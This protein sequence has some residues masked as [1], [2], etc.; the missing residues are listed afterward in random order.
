MKQISMA[1]LSALVFSACAK[2]ESDFNFLPPPESDVRSGVALRVDPP[3]SGSLAVLSIQEGASFD[4]GPRSVNTHTTQTFTLKNES[5]SAPATQISGSANLGSGFSYVGGGFPGFSGTCGDTLAPQQS[6]TFVIEFN[7]LSLLS[8]T[9]SPLISYHDGA[10]TNSTS[11]LLSGIGAAYPTLKFEQPEYSFG[12]VNLGETNEMSLVVKYYGVHPA[13][14]IG[15][16]TL[17]SPW[18][19]KGGSYPGLGG[20]CRRDEIA[21]D[22]RVVVTFSPTQAGPNSKI[23]KLRYNNGAF[24]DDAS[25]VIGGSGYG[26]VSPR[27][28][29]LKILDNVN[30]PLRLVNTQSPAAEVRVKNDGD[31]AAT[32]VRP[33][34]LGDG[35]EIVGGGTCG[36]TIPTGICTFKVVFRPASIGKFSGGLTLIYDDGVNGWGKRVSNM[37]AGRAGGPPVLIINDVSPYDYGEVSVGVTKWHDF[38]ISNSPDSIAAANVNIVNTVF[39]F[40]SHWNMSGFCGTEIAPGASCKVGV[41][42]SP[43]ELGPRSSQFTVSYGYNDGTQNISQPTLLQQVKGV[44]VENA[45]LAID[46][47]SVN[48]GKVFVSKKAS[49]T[50]KLVYVG[51][52]VP[53]VIK[54]YEFHSNGKTTAVPF[55]Q[56]ALNDKDECAGPGTKMNKTCNIGL[57]FTPPENLSYGAE[58]WVLYDDGKGNTKTAKAGL[59]GI[60]LYEGALTV[61]PNPLAFGRVKLGD[62]LTKNV[63]LTAKAGNFTDVSV[64]EV[65]VTGDEFKLDEANKADG[66]SSNTGKHAVVCARVAAG[67]K[68]SVP[69]K[70]TPSNDGTFDGKVTV[71]WKADEQT[72]STSQTIGLTGEGFRAGIVEVTPNPA[73]IE[74]TAV[75]QSNSVTVTVKNKGTANVTDLV[76]ASGTAGKA[77]T[78]NEMALNSSCGSTL[79]TSGSGSSC[80]FQ[81]S[82][83]PTKPGDREGEVVVSFNDG[84]KNDSVKVP[85]KARSTVQVQLASGGDHACAITAIGQVKCWGRNDYGQLGVGGVDSKGDAGGEMGSALK[86]VNLGNGR[87]AKSVSVGFFHTCAILDNDTLKCWGRNDYGQLGIGNFNHKGM[88]ESDMGDALPGVALGGTVKAVEAGYVHTCAILTDGSVKCWGLNY[89]GQLGLGDRTTRNAPS[90]AADIGGSAKSISL[91]AGHTC[92]VLTNNTL[93]CWGDNW[94]GQLG[95][96]DERGRGDDAGEMGSALAAIELGV[97]VSGVTAAGGYTC[98]V[99]SNGDMKCFGRNQEGTLGTCWALNSSNVAGPCWETGYTRDTRGYG[100]YAGQMSTLPK[101]DLGSFSVKTAAAGNFFVCAADSGGAV[102]CFG[103]NYAGQLG[104][105][106]TN[107]RGDQVGEM[108]SAL[109]HINVG[110]AVKTIAPGNDHACV[111]RTDNSVVCF[112]ENRYGQLGRG[113]S[114]KIGDGAG[115]MGGALK[116]VVLE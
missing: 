30:F 35:F 113:D 7:P 57:E 102:K 101:V 41:R 89:M 106:D 91:N 9:S 53:A 104:Y 83:N 36:T 51:G 73:N 2:H 66:V 47:S 75:G 92:A 65:K 15:E 45:V 49:K 62:S 10:G 78:T 50:V 20:D 1:L 44:G 77:L 111:L 105:G 48:F 52:L 5:D 42:F 114:I 80:T 26:Q 63:E 99:L 34:G 13:T 90:A 14:A 29:S 94:Y 58:F 24:S 110:G 112:G 28:A 4:Y 33:S 74:N 59:S 27:P 37:L 100:I 116:T 86:A 17:D 6:C 70:F 81:V 107:S 71:V 82:F 84:T 11:I 38:W 43:N 16:T 115:E 108:G 56:V 98:A 55:T 85:V 64:S 32:N 103:Q 8:Y 12:S 76:V 93:K 97:Q 25:T 18:R 88:S 19:Y 46:P 72:T 31:L 61:T 3:Y 60:G 39:P 21:A 67:Q 54:G 95:Q 109:T 69:V 96:N 40:V 79:T 68:C 23:L 22:C 87:F